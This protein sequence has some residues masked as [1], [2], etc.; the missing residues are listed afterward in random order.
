[1]LSSVSSTSARIADARALRTT[2]A[3]M[4][5]S[6]TLVTT[7]HDGVD[8]GFTAN[9]FT[10]VSSEPPLVAV[11]LADT[12]DSYGAFA[13]S[14]RVAINILAD[15]HGELARRFATKGTD[16]FAEFDAHPDHDDLPVLSDAMATLLT[17]V[18]S[19]V[20]CGDHL[21]LLLGVEDVRSSDRLPLVYQDR[22]FRTLA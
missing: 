18:E 16:K 8:Y 7:R 15:G 6:V 12:A 19:R 2:L 10:S 9:S 11:F 1:M 22:T 3:R 13:R 21:M 14:E 17:R 20:T 5:T 4:A